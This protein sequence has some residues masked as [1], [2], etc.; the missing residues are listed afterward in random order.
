MKFIIIA[1]S[2]LLCLSSARAGESYQVA[3]GIMSVH[4]KT[5]AYTITGVKID[6]DTMP[7]ECTR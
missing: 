1:L 6:D 5:H 2:I 4:D 3:K 7:N